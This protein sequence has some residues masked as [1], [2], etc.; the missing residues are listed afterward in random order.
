MNNTLYK[1]PDHELPYN[2]DTRYFKNVTEGEVK[3]KYEQRWVLYT[4]EVNDFV[5]NASN[6]LN[7][8]ALSAV[9]RDDR[10]P[11]TIVT[12]N[13]GDTELSEDYDGDGETTWWTYGGSVYSYH[14][15]R[16]V[17]NTPD[18]IKQ[19]IEHCLHDFGYEDDEVTVNC[20]PQAGA[21]RVMCEATFT[22]NLELDETNDPTTS[23]DFDDEED[24]VRET[25]T[26]YNVQ[27]GKDIIDLPI[28]LHVAHHVGCSKSDAESYIKCVQA[29]QRGEIRWL[30]PPACGGGIT[31]SGWYSTDDNNPNWMNKPEYKGDQ[32]PKDKIASTEL[33][34]ASVPQLEV[35]CIRATATTTVKAREK[36]TLQKLIE[37]N[38]NTG[39]QESITVGGH[40]I[41]CPKNQRG[42]TTDGQSSYEL[43]SGGW[44]Q[45]GV[46]FD[47]SSIQKKT[48]AKTGKKYYEG[49]MTQSWVSY[50][51]AVECKE[52]TTTQTL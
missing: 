23:E 37:D 12:L 20:N 8:L 25:L 45:E 52:S 46:S 50:Y 27:V 33:Y 36:Q 19:F 30:E 13:Y 10:G 26:N 31:E 43:Y 28:V 15:R 18:E 49:N 24:K 35:P 7:G 4:N 38:M 14:I 32:Y 9:D 44:I 47:A 17:T 11:L 16:W 6:T 2:I 51:S 48:S 29:L 34:M 22:P 42:R 3:E 5:L 40:S 1:K 21:P 39:G 41:K